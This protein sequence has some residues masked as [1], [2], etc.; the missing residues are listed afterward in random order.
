MGR[1]VI[2]VGWGGHSRRLAGG[3]GLLVRN[4]ELV[5][6][7]PDYRKHQEQQQQQ[8][9]KVKTPTDKQVVWPG[10]KHWDLLRQE[11]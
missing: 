4:V 7:S 9:R 6:W 10:G 5:L 2:V 1:R 8:K 3:W 11:M